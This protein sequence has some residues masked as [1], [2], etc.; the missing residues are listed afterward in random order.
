[1]RRRLKQCDFSLLF[2]CS[3]AVVGYCFLIIEEIKKHLLISSLNRRV[4]SF[5]NKYIFFWQK[6]NIKMDFLEEFQ[7]RP[8]ILNS[9]I[10]KH[11]TEQTGRLK[12]DWLR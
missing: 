10:S 9:I 2:T 7:N 8:F 1:M 4:N 5:F 6:F 12:A 3:K 11:S